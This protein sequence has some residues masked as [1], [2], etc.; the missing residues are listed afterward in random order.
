M[1]PDSSRGAQI[2]MKY[3][4][5]PKLFP[6]RDDF[7]I[8]DE[9]GRDTFRVEDQSSGLVRSQLS[10]QDL[11]GKEIASISQNDLL[12]FSY[13]I[14]KE[15]QP[16]AVVERGFGFFRS[17]FTVRV[18]GRDFILAKGNFWDFE[19][20]FT[21]GEK[22]IATVRRRGD[23]LLGSYEIQVEPQEDDILILTTAVVIGLCQSNKD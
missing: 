15:G 2:E 1:Q 3:R 13:D 5:K 7:L 14:H 8:Q 23:G 16:W 19:Y 21:R 11:S 12:G 10:F 4:L 20:D 9:T 17:K 22:T 18:G 6:L